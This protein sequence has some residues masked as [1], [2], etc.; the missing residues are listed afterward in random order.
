M[1]H[2]KFS[3]EEGYDD[4]PVQAIESPKNSVAS[5]ARGTSPTFE[6]LRNLDR[7]IGRRPAGSKI[8]RRPVSSERVGFLKVK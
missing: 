3:W 8:R 4:E 6:A 7:D 1:L 2:R 5:N